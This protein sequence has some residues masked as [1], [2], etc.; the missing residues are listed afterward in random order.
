MTPA[1][2][3]SGSTP[4]KLIRDTILGQDYPRKIFAMLS[5]G[6]AFRSTLKFSP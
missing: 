6:M 3:F 5:N 4:A 1:A 2:T